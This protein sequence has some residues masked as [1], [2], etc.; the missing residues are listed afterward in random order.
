[1]ERASERSS[2]VTVGDLFGG[3]APAGSERARIAFLMQRDG[4]ANTVEWV[5]RTLGIYRSALRDRAG[6]GGAFRRQLVDSCCNFR[7]WLRRLDLQ[8]PRRE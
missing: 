7:R 8:A 1:M 4:A 6:Y 5:R 2:P 3:C